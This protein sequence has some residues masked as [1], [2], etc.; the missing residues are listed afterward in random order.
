MPQP[1]SD[2]K[3]MQV[4]WE[5]VEPL[6]GYT[7]RRCGGDPALAEDLTQETWLR[8]LREWPRKGLPDVP[9]A[10]LTTVARNLIVDRLRR[11]DRAT[12]DLIGAAENRSITMHCIDFSFAV[13]GKSGSGLVQLRQSGPEQLFQQF[14]VRLP[15]DG[16]VEAV[17]QNP[18][19]WM[20]G[21]FQESLDSISGNCVRMAS[22][23]ERIVFAFVGSIEAR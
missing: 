16:N 17:L 22:I 10:W 13:E 5:T 23:T 19:R 15:I 4:S 12:T 6:Y 18:S 9:L 20:V 11:R 1:P 7:S 2:A 3:L 21:T 14:P 8:A